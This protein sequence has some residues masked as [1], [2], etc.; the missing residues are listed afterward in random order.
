MVTNPQNDPKP[1]QLQAWL[2][3]FASLA[4]L[5]GS[6]TFNNVSR[7]SPNPGR[8]K[9]T[10]QGPRGIQAGD[11]REVR[12][13]ILH[14]QRG[15]EGCPGISLRGVGADRAEAGPALQLQPYEEKVSH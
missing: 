3:A 6:R 12:R 10:P 8:R 5:F 14:H 2:T 13:A 11:R 15:W 4:A 7:Q 1:E 9:G